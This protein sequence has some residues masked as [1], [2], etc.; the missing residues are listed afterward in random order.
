[1]IPL[2]LLF[3]LVLTTL[4]LT[5]MPALAQDDLPVTLTWT[6]DETDYTTRQV[7]GDYDNDGDL[8]LFVANGMIY[9]ENVP[10]LGNVGFPNRRNRLYCNEK[11][12]LTACWTSEESEF[13]L[14]AAW[15]D[16]DGDGDL[17]LA[18]GNGGALGLGEVN[19]IYRNDTNPADK[20]PHF[21]LAWTSDENLSTIDVAWGD[22][23]GDRDLDLAVANG[24]MFFNLLN[25][26]DILPISQTNQ[27]YINDGITITTRLANL[28]LAFQ[29]EL[30]A[31]SVSQSLRQALDETGITLADNAQVV[32][33]VR[34]QQWRLIHAGPPYAIIRTANGLDLYATKLHFRLDTQFSPPPDPSFGIDWVDVDSDQDLDLA[35]ANDGIDY[36]YCND[37]NQAPRFQECW[38]SAPPGDRTISMSWG[39]YNG[40]GKPD[41]AMGN[42]DIYKGQRNRI[43]VNQGMSG[44]KLLLTDVATLFPALRLFPEED[45][46]LSIA[47]GDADGDGDLDLATGN[48]NFSANQPNRIYQNNTPSGAITPTFVLAWSSPETDLTTSIAWGDVDN[49]G[50]LDLAAGNM[51]IPV[52]QNN[53]LYRN[54][55]VPLSIEFADWASEE[56]HWTRAVAWGD[57]DGDGDLDL[58]LG[59]DGPEL[60]YRNDHGQLSEGEFIGVGRDDNT[61]TVAWGDMDGDGDLD[62]VVGN[63][64]N[65]PNQIYCNESRPN[66]AHFTLQPLANFSPVADT[67]SVAW[68]DYD[69][70]GDLDLAFGNGSLNSWNMPVGAVNQLYRNDG[71]TA[72]CTVTFT[73]VWRSPDAFATTSVA[74]GDVDGDGDLDLAIGN[75][76]SSNQLYRN[77]GVIAANTPIFTLAWTSIYTDDT[78]SVAWG[79]M[80]GDGDLD[81]ATGNKTQSNRVYCNVDGMLETQD[82][83]R[84]IEAERTRSVAWGDMDGDGDLDLAVGNQEAPN[85][86]YLNRGKRLSERAAWHSDDRNDRQADPNLRSWT[87]SVAWGDMDGDGDLELAAGNSRHSYSGVYR[88]TRFDHLANQP[89]PTAQ[90]TQTVAIANFYATPTIW[91]TA[92][93]PITYTLWQ[94]NSHPAAAVRGFYSLIGGGHWEPA[95]LSATATMTNQMAGPL[96][97][98]QVYTWDVAHS[99]FTGQS[100]NVAFR[101]ETLPALKPV[102]NTAPGPFLYGS[103][104]TQS[105]PF[106][107]RGNQVRVVNEDGEPMP[108]AVIYRLPQGRQTGGCPLGAG[109][110]GCTPSAAEPYTT[111]SQG[112]LQ[113]RSTLAIGDRLLALAPVSSTITYTTRYSDAIQLY[114]TNGRIAPTGTI[115]PVLAYTVTAQGVQ[116]LTVSADHPLILF[117]LT[118]SLEWDAQQDPVYLQQLAFDLAQ[119]S[120]Y[121]YDFTDGQVALG[122]VTVF[123]DAD[124]WAYAH[125]NIHATNRLRPYA[126]IGGAVITDTHDF[127]PTIPSIYS[128]GQIHMGS[129][130][131]R[132][133]EPNGN[134]GI[135]WPLILAH[136]FGHYF[137]FLEDTYLGLDTLPAIGEPV[138]VNV[139][140]CTGSAMGDVYNAGNTE[141]VFDPAHWQSGCAKTLAE[142]ELARTEWQTLHGWYPDLQPPTQT[143]A[144]PNFMPFALTTVAITPPF[145]PT[146]ALENQVFYL[147]YGAPSDGVGSSEARAFLLRDDNDD[148]AT[149]YLYDLGNAIG[150]QNLLRARGAQAGDQLCVFDRP[151]RNSGCETIRAGD[152]QIDLIYDPDWNPIIQISPVTSTTLTIRVTNI[153]TTVAGLQLQAQLFPEFGAGTQ[154]YTLTQESDSFHTTITLT[155][156]SLSGHLHLWRSDE[157]RHAVVAYTIGGNPG[158]PRSSGGG[159]SRAGGGNPRS[160]GGGNPRSSG[161][162]NPRSSGGGEVMPGEAPLVSP[163][164]QM[165]FFA[166]ERLTFA[167]G[168]FFSI[169]DMAG[170][171][172]LP[173]GKLAIGQ[174]YN[175]FAS[176]FPSHTQVLTGSISFQYLGSDIATAKVDEAGLTIHFWDGETWHALPTYTDPYFNLASARSQGAG[177][178]ALLAG[179]TQPRIAEVAPTVLFTATNSLTPTAQLTI[180]GAHF[181]APVQ[182]RLTGQTTYT[183]AAQTISTHTVVASL[184]ITMTPDEYQLSV[185]NGDGGETAAT[186]S[187]TLLPRRALCFYDDFSSGPNQWTRSGDWA[188]VRLPSGR[189]ALSDSPAGPYKDASHYADGTQTIY[190]TTVTALVDLTNCA[191]PI[192][193]FDHIYQLAETPTGQDRALVQSST[194]GQSWTTLLTYPGSGAQRPSC[195]PAVAPEVGQGRRQ[196]PATEWKNNSWQCERVALPATGQPIWLRFSLQVDD[197]R[198]TSLGWLIDNVQIAAQE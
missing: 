64:G 138:L 30:N 135:D 113:G 50:D 37:Q 87:M 42:G 63:G 33:V 77:D 125:L 48:G 102:T 85:Q 193:T 67:S 96:G 128:I 162:G 131:N 82:C 60:I 65:D 132:Y 90:L 146:Q 45:A 192:L 179:V 40:D 76:G 19:H 13:T 120:R 104:G 17:D 89:S 122:K 126:T 188:I 149:D 127:S 103:A 166:T 178:Y 32:S 57:A 184:P 74:W 16:V 172:A 195:S 18:V 177:I 21:V 27:I 73:E 98:T 24:S 151:K 161:G 130:W 5:V 84:S 191:N 15:G 79:D 197:D 196:P 112:Y 121:L 58:A 35:V 173:A 25:F 36:V 181:L 94:T 159:Q 108:G 70:D 123:Q 156:P 23:D 134:G 150:T 4:F 22:Y 99:A 185:R 51:S 68:G 66:D 152:E 109:A 43:Y 55:S 182:L 31:G 69:G 168:Q 139:N 41:L 180:T 26:H 190:T 145:T 194:D 28:Q 6:S 1:L 39:D 187:L 91:T 100:D 81:L 148:G 61:R 2:A 165:I 88:N 56:P 169:Q 157:P 176:G 52:G 144:G 160:S 49:D 170:L 8:D 71:T 143:I 142:H 92:T 44:T 9:L 11:G 72:P 29:A 119:A 167:A 117:D 110:D 3:F 7:W 153:A 129:V 78:Q 12:V 175:L 93:L 62:L 53:R 46:T 198:L 155:E 38:R 189:R 86:I 97:V 133:G 20:T 137:L 101:V 59:N 47:W 107:V 164:G 54:D 154:V 174:G 186:T 116:T 141:L 171:P 136:E 14:G 95:V 80:D 10:F 124:N 83:W 147:S 140:T 75:A 34:D 163:D 115:T 118:A 111:D 106:R 158:N 183:L 105:Y 114:H